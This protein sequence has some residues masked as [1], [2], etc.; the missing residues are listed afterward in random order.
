MRGSACG[1]K[2]PY[3]LCGREHF[4]EG[5]KSTQTFALPSVQEAIFHTKESFEERKEKSKGRKK[6]KDLKMCSKEKPTGGSSP[7]SSLSRAFLCCHRKGDRMI[8]GHNRA[9]RRCGG[10]RGER[11][12]TGY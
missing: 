12:G 8:V 1:F 11:G 2:E 3:R 7:L 10:T 5:K 9:A 4:R 6:R